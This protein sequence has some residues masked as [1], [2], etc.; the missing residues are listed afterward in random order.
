MEAQMKSRV[1]VNE[2][3]E[4]YIAVESVNC[5]GCAFKGATGCIEVSGADCGFR[6]RDNKSVIFIKKPDVGLKWDPTDA[7]KGC[8]AIESLTCLGCIFRQGNRSC[9]APAPARCLPHMRKDG[10]SVHFIAL[11][12]PI[13][14]DDFVQ[15]EPAKDTKLA[16]APKGYKA[17]PEINACS[18]CAFDTLRR[19]PSLPCDKGHTL[20]GKAVIFIEDRLPAPLEMLGQWLYEERKK[21]LAKLIS[22]PTCGCPQCQDARYRL[23][24]IAEVIAKVEELASPD[25]DAS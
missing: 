19:H 9:T 21:L 25:P 2:A 11:P 5:T 17:V 3:P 23:R 18:G 7:P 4:G 20:S 6:R 14:V 10:C 13:E 8:Q 15:T 1:N 22:K 12:K 24:T 16:E